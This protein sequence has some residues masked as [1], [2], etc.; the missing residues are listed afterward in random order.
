[1]SKENLVSKHLNIYQ[2]TTALCGQNAL[3]WLWK[4]L[5]KDFVQVACRRALCSASIKALQSC[6]SS[7]EV[8]ERLPYVE[9][10]RDIEEHGALCE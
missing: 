5:L 6:A 7:R 4:G 10:L 2:F 9:T 1:M 8:N 3:G